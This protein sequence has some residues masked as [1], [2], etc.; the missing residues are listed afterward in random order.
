MLK[1]AVENSHIIGLLYDFKKDLDITHALNKE[2]EEKII[3]NPEASL[4]R[5]ISLEELSRRG[6]MVS[7]LTE[8]NT[9]F[10]KKYGLK[11]FIVKDNMQTWVFNHVDPASIFP[12]F[13]L[14]S[15]TTTTNDNKRFT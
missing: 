8:R 3:S 1:L 2:E 10:L 6:F 14:L 9:N 4:D 15:D 11:N 13:Q 7:G 5:E 12:H